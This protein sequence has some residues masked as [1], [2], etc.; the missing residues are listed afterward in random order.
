M[1]YPDLRLFKPLPESAK[2]NDG[3][4]VMMY[5]G[6][7][8]YHQ[9]LD[10]G[11]KAFARVKDELP[12]AEFHI[13]GTGPAKPE[14]EVLIHQLNLSDCVFLYP[15]QSIDEISKIMA[16]ADLGIIPKRSDGFGNEAF[17]T[18]S[19]EFMACGIPIIISG[20]RIDRFFF[21]DSIVV[22]FNPQDEIALADAI[23]RTAGDKVKM[24][25]L[26][27][28][29]LKFVLE[30]N[31]KKNKSLYNKIMILFSLIW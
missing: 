25:H 1:N 29:A 8:N 3:K 31:W 2:R 14:L 28:K 27:Q 19:L 23:R 15:E 6:S 18:K 21:N 16:N 5:P 24:R 20:T 10:L 4:F 9:G 11:V 17:S 12:N 22:F 26:S 13:Y 7:M 30:K